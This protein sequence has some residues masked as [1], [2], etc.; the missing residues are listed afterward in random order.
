[1]LEGLA[2]WLLKTY[3]GK[4]VNLNAD[5]LSVGLLSGSVELENLPIKKD[6]FNDYELPFEVKFGHIGKIKLN[7]SLNKLRNTPWSLLAE[8]LYLII[9][10]K[11]TSTN[12]SNNNYNKSEDL[13]NS[14]KEKLDKLKSLDN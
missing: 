14:D 6:A 9:G 11:N 1:M 3:I 12:N 5:K 13:L 4:Y 2:A 10:P 8:G 7:I